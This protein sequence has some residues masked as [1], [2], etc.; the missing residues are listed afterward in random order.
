M[1]EFNANEYPKI[2]EDLWVDLGKLGCIMVDLE[3]L[4][5]IKISEELLYKSENKDRYWIDWMVCD[6]IAHITLLYWL[7]ESWEKNKEHVDTLLDGINLDKFKI[8]SVW[9]FD[10][11]LEDEDYYCIIA[12]IEVTPELKEAHAK[13]QMLPHINTYPEFKPHM[14]VAYIK[15]DKTTLD[16]IL[17]SLEYLVGKEVKAKWINY[18]K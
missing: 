1:K 10:S 12:H 13:L 9:K 5:E 14:T 15:K 3:P 16:Y 4:T 11:N 18:G 2:Y 8:S 6:N 17:S 7:M